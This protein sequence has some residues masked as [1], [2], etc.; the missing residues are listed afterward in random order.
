MQPYFDP[1]RKTTSQKNRKRLLKKWKMED[2]LKKNKKWKTT[3]ILRQ[4]FWDYLTT[5]TSK[6]NGNCHII[7]SIANLVPVLSSI[8]IN[9]FKI[10]GSNENEQRR[11]VQTLVG[12]L[13]WFSH[14]IR[15]LMGT[16]VPKWCTRRIILYLLY[17][18][19]RISGR[20]AP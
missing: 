1:T 13:D 17:L 9:I 16:N 20:Y 19:T 15:R 11:M 2:D 18:V 3:S 7:L 6:T 12:R 8:V 14:F 5:K 4:S 10:Y